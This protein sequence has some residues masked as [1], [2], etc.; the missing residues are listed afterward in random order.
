MESPSI[1]GHI[2]DKDRQE[3]GLGADLDYPF[4]ESYLY[5]KTFFKD[6][7]QDKKFRYYD[8]SNFLKFFFFDWVYR[9]SKCASTRFIESYKLHPLPVSDQI[10]RW[11]PVFSKHVS[12][13]LVRLELF[14]TPKSHTGNLGKTSAYRFVLLRAIF[15]TFWKRTLIG[16]MG[17]IITNIM[18]MSIAILVKKLL[19]IL[20]DQTTSLAKT[21]LL[22]FAIILFNLVDGLVVDNITF[23]LYRLIY[24]IQCCASITMFQHGLCHRRNFSNDVN[25]SNYLGVCNQVLHTCSPDSKCSQN[26]LFCQALRYQN[27]ELNARI[28]TFQ[29]SDCYYISMC[30]ESLIYIVNFL[31]SFIHGIIL[32][33]L[34]FK[35]K[36]WILYFIGVPFVVVMVFVEALNSYFLSVAYVVKDFR[37]SKSIEIVSSLPIIIKMAFDRIAMNIITECRNSELLFFLIRYFLTFLN[38]SLFVVFTNI[39]FYILKKCFVKAVNEATVITQIDTAGFMSTFYILLQIIESMFLVPN[40]FRV[41]SSSYV[42][43][44]RV[45]KYLKRCSPNFY[46]SDNKYT[47]SVKASSN[48]VQVTDEV[49]NDAVVYYKDASF[50]WVCSSKDLLDYN[51]EPS[52]NNVNFQLKRGEIAIITGAQGSGKSN[53]IKS[54]LGEMTLV[55]GSMAVVPLHTSMPIFYASQDIW[56]HQGTIRSN[57]TFGY[58]FDEQIYN[59]V[60]KAVELQSDISTWEKGDLRVVSD[61][62]HTLSGGQRVRMEM[63]RAIYA[64]LIF[65][66]VNSD[67]NNGKCSF[68]MCLDS[69]F[70]GLDPFVSKT[71]F[72]NLFNIK[73]GV[74]I[75]DDLSVV[76]SSTRRYLHTCLEPSGLKGAPNFPIYRIKNESLKFFCY[77]HDFIN[78][79]VHTPEDFKYLS[80]NTGPY[81]LNLLTRDMLNL[82]SSGSTTRLGRREVTRT[83]YD[84]SFK[85]FVR[86]E[87]SGVKFNPYFVYMKPALALFT[88]FIALTFIFTIMDN[89]KFVLSSNLSDFITNKIGEF[90]SGSFVDFE[91]VKSRCNTSLFIIL[92]ITTIIVVLAV[93]S[94]ILFSI[95][96]IVSSRKIHEYCINSIF[97]NSSSVIKIK[98]QVSQIITYLSCDIDFLDDDLPYDFYLSLVSFIQMLIDIVTLFYFIPFSIVFTTLAI[99]LFHYTVF[100]YYLGSYKHIQLAYLECISHINTIFENAIH[101]SSICRGYKKESQQV[102]IIMESNEYFNRHYFLLYAIATWGSMLF[103]WIFS[104]NALLILVIPIFFNKYAKYRLKTGD[105]GLSLSL[106]VDVMKTYTTFSLRFARMAAF[107]TSIQRFRYFIPPGEKVKFGKFFNAH[108]EF[109]AKPSGGDQNVLN[110]SQL[111]KRRIF[112]FKCDD[113]KFKYFRKLLFNPKINIMNINNYLPPEHS[114]IE[115]KNVCVYTEAD[116]N[117]EGMILKNITASANRSEIIGMVGRTGSG[118]TTLLSVIQNIVENRTGQVLLDGKE[119]NEVPKEVLAQVVGV[120]PQLPFVFKGWTIRRF[121]DP[122]KLFSDDEIIQALDL[123]G[124][125]DFVND[126][127]GGKKLDTIISAE[128]ISMSKKNVDVGKNHYPSE[129]MKSDRSLTMECLKNY[130]INTDITLSNTQ[131]RTLAFTRLVL[132]RQFYR[133]ILVDEPPAN[134]ISDRPNIQDVDIGIPIYELLQKHFSHCTTFVAAHDDNALSMCTL[135]WV[136]HK[137][138]IMMK[139]GIEDIKLNSYISTVIEH[140]DSL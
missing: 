33:S 113:K 9:W 38:T 69:P 50:A 125:L 1:Y 126:L 8:L 110:E 24:I 85:S 99:L 107:I 121:L 10:L 40:S 71:V 13:G 76:L 15:L 135:V 122:R 91:K 34:Q 29:F 70:H 54:M 140:L 62:A 138:S 124:L 84:K 63:A 58:R 92:I 14:K 133:I 6:K 89:L 127:Q 105:Y 119:I 49:P 48:V 81:Q 37:I 20:N 31:T 53:F 83:K 67:Y 111:L 101:G 96:C 27:K 18:S 136:I 74:L 46:I 120:L 60:L 39:S 109:V 88:L 19:G 52:L 68:L 66:Q 57:I 26:P 79:K 106:L 47:G 130:Y 100:T 139:Y 132:Y 7:N 129:S 137:G 23:Y 72:N 108:E 56:L 73:T 104:C 118:K 22:L 87:L 131:L 75:K 30:L 114:G 25:G 11:Q 51:Y 98:K 123:C 90:N 93:I 134:N 3:D 4:W 115:L 86:D 64:Y 42:A 82:C 28:V 112:E 55:G 103:N 5:D 45:G 128:D 59:T 43:Y 44:R 61:N 78:N 32:M 2:P 16:L 12:D 80:T 35:I 117:S 41:I 102:D 97:K 17:I 36:L 116:H 94:T 65:H 95:S 21:I 77:L